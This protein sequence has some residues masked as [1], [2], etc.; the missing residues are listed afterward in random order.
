MTNPLPLPSADDPALDP[1]DMDPSVDP[2]I[3]FYAYANGGWK[4]RNPVPPQYSRW[5]A[6]EEIRRSNEDLIRTLLE[7][8]AAVPEGSGKAE[9]LAGAYYRAGMNTDRI[10]TAGLEPLRRLLEEIDHIDG[11]GSLRTV[12]ARLAP[13]GVSLPVSLSVAPDFDNSQRHLLYLGQGGLGLPERDYYFRDDEASTTLRSQYEEHIA[14]I[15]ELSQHADPVAAATRILELETALAE[16]AHTAT[17]LRDLD[18]VLNRHTATEIATLMPSYDLPQLLAGASIPRLEAVNVGNPDFLAVADRI[19]AETP[20][21]TL[22]AYARWA[23]LRATA[24][25]L[26]A[27]FE[28][29]SFRFY[30]QILG[31]QQQQKDRWQR[32]QRAATAEI[33]QV[34]SQL[35]VARAFGPDSRERAQTLVDRLLEAMGNSIREATW[36]S[37]ETAHAALAKLA[38]FTTKIGYPDVWID[39]SG[40]HLSGEHAWITLRLAARAFEFRRKVAQLDEPVDPNEWAMAPHEVNA[41]FHPLRT[42]IA[43]PAGILQPPFF[44][45]AADDAVNY[46]AIG[47]IIGHEITHGFD[48]K[49]SRFDDRGQFANWWQDDDRAEFERRA[50]VLVDQF[51]S[52]QVADDLSVNGR[53][54]LGENIADLGGVSIAYR[55]LQHAIAESGS[56]ASVGGM[57]PEQRFFLS[58]AR[59]WRSNETEEYLRLRVQT[60]PHSPPMYRCNGP[61]GN[62]PEFAAAFGIAEGSPMARSA[63]ERA[64]VW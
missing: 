6:F 47:A 45:A 7:S 54:T 41:Y 34:V 36:M 2:A 50:Q 64:K 60:D 28:D 39:Y 44:D 4:A 52:Y 32:V 57:T 1:A 12:A 63:E 31:G 26:P 37:E 22:R 35:Y 48:D 56:D 8:A 21:S 51:D 42:E 25:G 59:A 11:P 16:A 29:E 33:G 9:E 46:G 43:F 10:E 38:A 49:G 13:M 18:L 53:L 15:L 58:Y 23:A 30:G 14:A 3:D 62:T 55:A 24:S 5:A 61:L 27:V 19:L 20:S 40:L 17:E